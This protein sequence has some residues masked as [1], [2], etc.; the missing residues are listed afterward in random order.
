MNDN[1]PWVIF[2]E[3]AVFAFAAWLCYMI[4]SC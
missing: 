4:A 1:R 2:C 3:L